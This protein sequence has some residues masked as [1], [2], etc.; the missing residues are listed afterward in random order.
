MINTHIPYDSKKRRQITFEM[1][2]VRIDRR[3]K[4]LYKYLPK[5]LYRCYDIIVEVTKFFFVGID[6]RVKKLYEY[7]KI[8]FDAMIS[9]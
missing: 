6:R 1:T 4:K 8:Y 3:V 5:Y 2:I 7:L 9:L